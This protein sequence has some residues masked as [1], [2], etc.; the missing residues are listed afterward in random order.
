MER[1]ELALIAAGLVVV[2]ALVEAARLALT[3]W[4]RGLRARRRAEVARAGEVEAEGL[5]ERRGY[6]ILARQP[7][8]SLQLRV[9]GAPREIELRADL[10]VS[11]RGRTLIAEVKTGQKAPRLETK[12]TRRQLLEYLV[13][14]A[15]AE[16][17][18]LVDASAGT[19]QEVTFPIELGPPRGP[20]KLTVALGGVVLGAAAATAIFWFGG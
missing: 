7:R 13:T 5:L 20:S 10:L 18:L 16:G 6:R 14:Y 12:A 17:V 9:D 15:E 19:I 8:R 3:R 2:V 11:R 4:L 1:S